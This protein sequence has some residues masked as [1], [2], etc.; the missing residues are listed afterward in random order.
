MKLLELLMPPESKKKNNSLINKISIFLPYIFIVVSFGWYL[1]N[2]D[3]RISLV[4][5][6]LSTQELDDQQIIS[7][8]QHV[9]DKVDDLYKIIIEKS[10]TKDK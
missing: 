1:A 10:E 5:S 7:N 6:T 8:I 9:Q 2:Q 4:E 3:K